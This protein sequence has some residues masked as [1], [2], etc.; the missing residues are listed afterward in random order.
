[1]CW[2]MTALDW[3][4]VACNWPRPDR[5]KRNRIVPR[6]SAFQTSSDASEVFRS[7]YR[8][9]G[10]NPQNRVLSGLATIQPLHTGST[11][12]CL[13]LLFLDCADWVKG[14][15]RRDPR[16]R[17]HCL[18]FLQSFPPFCVVVCDGLTG[19]RAPLRPLNRVV[20]LRPLYAKKQSGF[21]MRVAIGRH[22]SAT[23]PCYKPVVATDCCRTDCLCDKCVRT[24]TFKATCNR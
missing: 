1:M 18:Q 12:F 19:S 21:A 6:E 9:P 23:C 3:S 11:R 13:L 17:R 10:S 14:R 24:M 4:S 5:M 8:L 15:L 7:Y 2:Q 16:E 22:G 20:I